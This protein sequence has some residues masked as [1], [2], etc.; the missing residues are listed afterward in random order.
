MIYIA[1]S[2]VTTL[3]DNRIIFKLHSCP[4]KSRAGPIGAKVST[5]KTTI[6]D[7]QIRGKILCELVEN[8]PASYGGQP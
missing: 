8:V 6:I 5:A 3:I 7:V 1:V 4:V 2:S